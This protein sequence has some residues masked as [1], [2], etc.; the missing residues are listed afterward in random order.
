MAE[1]IKKIDPDFTGHG[2]CAGF[3]TWERLEVILRKAGE[4]REGETI[5]GYRAEQAG[6]NFYVKT[7]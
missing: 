1:I 2:G 6:V 3:F 5:E 7:I 4:L